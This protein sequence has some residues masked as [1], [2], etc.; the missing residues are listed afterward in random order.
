MLNIY[1][2]PA[3]AAE[4][5]M[6]GDVGDYDPSRLAQT[7]AQNVEWA[8]KALAGMPPHIVERLTDADLRLLAEVAA[9]RSWTAA[10]VLA[11]TR[12]ANRLPE[13]TIRALARA[14]ARAAGDATKVLCDISPH[15]AARL[16]DDDLR[17]LAQ[18]TTKSDDDL[19]EIAQAI[20]NGDLR[21]LAQATTGIWVREVL[22]DMPQHIAERLSQCRPAHALVEAGDTTGLDSSARAVRDA[23]ARCCSSPRC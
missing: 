13:E 4:R 11:E 14:A 7:A 16:S 19:R 9:Q 10:L 22:R 8:A 2:Y 21:N 17:E 3:F 12:A 5:L 1:Y 6:S 15:N 18:A 20:S 23:T